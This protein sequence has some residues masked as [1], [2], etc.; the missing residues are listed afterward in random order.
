M[1]LFRAAARTAV[2]TSTPQ[3]PLQALPVQPD[4]AAPVDRVTMIEQHQHLGE[5]RTA[6]AL[7]DAELEAQ[8]A[9]V[10]GGA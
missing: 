2:S 8:K 7:T 4:P 5:L 9:L 6:G 3:E 10:L 1:G